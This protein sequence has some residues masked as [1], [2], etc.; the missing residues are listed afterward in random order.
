MVAV[1]V[2]RRATEQEGCRGEECAREKERKIAQPGRPDREIER[3]NATRRKCGA[4]RDRTSAKEI[5]KSVIARRRCVLSLLPG[6]RDAGVF[7]CCVRA[8][9]CVRRDIR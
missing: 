5:K 7:V 9:V 3:A 1:S 2:L 6:P 8:R 4:D